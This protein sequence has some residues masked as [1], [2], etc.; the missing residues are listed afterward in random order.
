MKLLLNHN[1]YAE[2]D[3]EDYERV[4]KFVWSYDGE[5]ATTVPCGTST[6]IYLHRFIVGATPDDPF[7]DHK[8]RDKLNCKKSNLRFVTVQQNMFNSSGH[9]IKLS[10]LPKG[11]YKYGRKFQA[12]IKHNGVQQYLGV[13]SFVEDAKAAYRAKA[14]ELQGEYAAHLTEDK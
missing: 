5:Y 4:S 8:D 7:I 6:K 11:V 10:G 2:I 1:N 12:I 3:E 14:K 13:F 9:K